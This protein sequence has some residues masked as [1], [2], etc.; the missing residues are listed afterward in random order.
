MKTK[1][2]QKTN[3]LTRSDGRAPKNSNPKNVTKNQEQVLFIIDRK[4][5][6]KD[7]FLKRY[8]TI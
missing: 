4:R 8:L 6:N 1:T 5:L 2:F 7:Y 3:H